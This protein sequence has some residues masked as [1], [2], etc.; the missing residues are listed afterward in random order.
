MAIK[1]KEIVNMF[2]QNQGLYDKTFWSLLKYI[3]RDD[4]VEELKQLLKMH[5]DDVELVFWKKLDRKEIKNMTKILFNYNERNNEWDW[6][7]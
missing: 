1:E 2:M 5:F 7:A 3:A 6:S 4:E